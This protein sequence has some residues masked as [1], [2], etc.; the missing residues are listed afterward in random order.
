MFEAYEQNRT[1]P[2]KDFKQQLPGLRVELLQL[3]QRLNTAGFPV[4]VLF[5]GVDGAGKGES[6][7]FLNEWMDPRSIATHPYDL[8]SDEE[9]ERP[10]FWRYWR[11]LP[12]HGE[13][14]L[15]LSAWYSRPLLDRAMDVSSAQAFTEQLAHIRRFERMLADDGALIL[16]FWMHLGREQQAARL[17]QLEA[18][19]L[20]AWRVRDTDWQHWER[21]AYFVEAARVL[22]EATDKPGAPWQIVEGYEQGWRSMMVARTLRDALQQRLDSKKPKKQPKNASRKPVAQSRYPRLDALDLSLRLKKREYND[23]LQAAQ[24]RLNALQRQAQNRKLSTVMV[25]EGWDAAGKGG[26][27]RRV[28]QSLN[29]RDYRV[30]RIAAPSDEELRHHYLWRFW[31]HVPRGGKVTIYDRSWYG[32]VLV[33]RVEGFATRAAWQRAYA[34]INEFEDELTANGTVL[35]KFWVHIDPKEQYRRFQDREATP[36][37]QW[38]LTEEDWRNRDKWGDYVVAVDDLFR[39]TSSKQAPWTAVEGNDK[40][41]SRVRIIETVCT[42]LAEALQD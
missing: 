14:A 30:I 16:K 7:N 33:E 4:I 10:D 9:R 11:D 22:I 12:G 18:D 15:L 29:A 41:W 5:A 1:L 42:R 6:V 40:R 31:R 2:K 27:I 32:R 26:A 38:K 20:T 3:Q 13:I 21:Y 37:K 17:K 24:A 19:P 36:H 25:F 34:E 23:R 35:C 28:V 39:Y 8:P